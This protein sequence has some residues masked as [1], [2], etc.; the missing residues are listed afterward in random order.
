MAKR[1]QV[2]N[3]ARKRK[4]SPSRNSATTSGKTATTRKRSPARRTAE[5]V[6]SEL[7]AKIREVKARE[8]ARELK[9]S[10]SISKT[11]NVLRGIDQAL[12]FAAQEGNTTLRHALAGARRPLGDYL[13]SQGL[14]LPKV[15]LPRGRKPAI[16]R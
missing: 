1:K 8:K 14:K 10:P 2:S 7:P 13:T 3:S 5:E 4:A 15:K 16:L 9:R 11:V 12:E 6:I